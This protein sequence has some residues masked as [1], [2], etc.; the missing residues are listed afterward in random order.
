MYY[1]D[2]DATRRVTALYRRQQRRGQERLTEDD[3]AVA[4]ALA[5]PKARG[6]SPEEIVT[7]LHQIAQ[8]SNISSAD[9]TRLDALLLR[10]AETG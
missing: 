7:A 4:A 9:R 6:V 5:P 2:R 3:P 10:L 8:A 1:V